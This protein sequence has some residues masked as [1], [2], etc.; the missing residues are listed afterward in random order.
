MLSYVYVNVIERVITLTLLVC[1]LQESVPVRRTPRKSVRLS[2]HKEVVNPLSNVEDSPPT[3]PTP[4]APPIRLPVAKPAVAPETTEKQP[5]QVR[6]V[7][8]FL[9]MK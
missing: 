6:L 4:M 1:Y 3:P 7:A 9:C 2:E 5:V 8:D